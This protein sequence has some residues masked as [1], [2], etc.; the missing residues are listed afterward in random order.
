VTNPIIADDH[1]LGRTTKTSTLVNGDNLLDA[2][3]KGEAV[4]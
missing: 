2:M 1:G 4:K 3:G